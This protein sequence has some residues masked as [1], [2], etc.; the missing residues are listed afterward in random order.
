MLDATP[1]PEDC[2]RNTDADN[3]GGYHCRGNSDP[4][5]VPRLDGDVPRMGKRRSGQG[6][7]GK[8]KQSRH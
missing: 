2:A 8:R 7:E 3:A 4:V 5:I 1:P 6:D